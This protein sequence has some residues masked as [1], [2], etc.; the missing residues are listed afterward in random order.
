MST[1]PQSISKWPSLPVNLK[2]LFVDDEKS[3]HALFS[4]LIDNDAIELKT[5]VDGLEAL[6]M[7]ESF[8][9]D[10]VITDIRMPRMDGMALLKEILKRYPNIFTIL[11]T[12]Y[13]SIPDAVASIKKQVPGINFGVYEKPRKIIK[14]FFKK[15]K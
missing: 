10:V 15:K 6:T 13:S 5:A 3:L 9:A 2:L 8:P 1:S 7:L 4:R 12:G 11:I 14:T